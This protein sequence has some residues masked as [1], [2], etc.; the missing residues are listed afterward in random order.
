VSSTRQAKW[1]EDHLDGGFGQGSGPLVG[2][3]SGGWMSFSTDDGFD[4]SG[5]L[6]H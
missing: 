6:R 4:V 2:D 1:I 3:G 5:G